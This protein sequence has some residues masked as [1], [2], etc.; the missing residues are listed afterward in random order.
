MCKLDM[1][2]SFYPTIIIALPIISFNYNL[3]TVMKAI[4]DKATT[5]KEELYKREHPQKAVPASPSVEIK[6]P[7][8]VTKEKKVQLNHAGM[9]KIK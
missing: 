3:V 5:E 4:V 1:T 6:K 9:P 2:E 8:L 7:G